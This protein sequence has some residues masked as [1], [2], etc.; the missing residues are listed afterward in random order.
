[1]EYFGEVALG[2]VLHDDVDVVE[3]EEGVVVLDEV[4]VLDEF[5]GL[6]LPEGL[7]LLLL[8]GRGGGTWQDEI[9]TFFN[10]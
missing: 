1:M 9:F 10:A 7:D 2:G 4:G 5:E 8:L 6:E 3:G